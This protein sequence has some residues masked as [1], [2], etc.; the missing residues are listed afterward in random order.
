MHTASLWF[1]ART[2]RSKPTGSSRLIILQ[3]CIERSAIKDHHRARTTAISARPYASQRHVSAFAGPQWLG[4][5]VGDW[6][7]CPTRMGGG[8]QMTPSVRPA[9]GL[10][11]GVGDAGGGVGAL[12]GR[13]GSIGIPVSSGTRP[14]S[15]ASVGVTVEV[16]VGAI[17][18]VELAST[19]GGLLAP[20]P[21]PLGVARDA[22]PTEMTATR[23]ALK[24]VKSN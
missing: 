21:A 9:L 24:P 10:S 22:Q 12:N 19:A 4:V 16:G 20:V 1:P 13:S 8:S 23:Q 14:G 15:T 17:A 3:S 2:R 18:V 5:A 7:A 6:V 11:V